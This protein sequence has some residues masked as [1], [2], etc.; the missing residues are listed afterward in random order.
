V[1]IPENGRYLHADRLLTGLEVAQALGLADSVN[2][3]ERIRG[4]YRSGALAAVKVQGHLRYRPEDVRDYIER[5][6]IP[7]SYEAARAKRQR[8][9]ACG[10]NKGRQKADRRSTRGPR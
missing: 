9:V 2:P 10:A 3:S 8:P 5:C 4:I 6:R 7:A 1:G